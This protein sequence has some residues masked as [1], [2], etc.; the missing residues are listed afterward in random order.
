[1]SFIYAVVLTCISTSL[2]LKLLIFLRVF[3]IEAGGIGIWIANGFQTFFMYRRE[4]AQLILQ[5]IW[6]N[7][8]SV[9]RTGNQSDLSHSAFEFIPD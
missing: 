7:A 6:V 1:M 9:W 3:G 5:K 4:V 8:V 2:F